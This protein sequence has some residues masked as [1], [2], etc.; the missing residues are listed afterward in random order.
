MPGTHHCT[1]GFEVG[2]YPSVIG[3]NGKASAGL[4]ASGELQDA[5]E[6]VMSEIQLHEW[7]RG[8][9]ELKRH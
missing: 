5:R 3:T 2:L 7:P 9:L 8:R 1:S 4:Y 6:G